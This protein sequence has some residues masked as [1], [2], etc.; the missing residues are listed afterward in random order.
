MPQE[1]SDQTPIE[2]DPTIEAAV[3]GFGLSK[4]LEHARNHVR[5]PDPQATLRQT[6]DSLLGFLA[7]RDPIALLARTGL[8]VIDE[9][10]RTADDLVF[11]QCE[12]EILQSLALTLPQ[13]PQV[14]TSPRSIVRG[15]YLAERTVRAFSNVTGEGID[16]DDP[17][18]SITA[19]ARV[20]TLY[21][22]N[23]F[24]SEDAKA[25]LPT[26]L[27]PMDALSRERLGFC[28]SDFA[29]ALLGLLD[30]IGPRINAFEAPAMFQ[31]GHLDE[32]G[33]S[34]ILSTAPM[35]ERAWRFAGKSPAVTRAQC[36]FQLSEMA[37]APVFTFSQKE[38]QGWYGE[39]I[40][41]ALT[42]LS[43][44]FGDLA[45]YNLER[46]YLDS[47]IREQPFIRLHDDAL[48]L[49]VPGLL[50]SFPFQMIEGLIR[51]D[52]A[53]EAAYSHA[54]A[55][56]L[57][58]AAEAIFRTAMP[59]ARIYHPVRWKDPDSGES[60]ENDL[61]VMLGNHIFL[62]E[63]KSGKVKPASRRGG[64]ESLKKNFRQL[65]VEPGIQAHRLEAILR[66]GPEAQTLLRDS[67]GRPLDIDLSR[68]VIVHS[69]GICIEH[70]AAIT[71][72]REKFVSLGLIGPDDAW[73]PILSLG[74]LRM[75]DA[76]LDT[77]VS[78]FHYLTRRAAIEQQIS[79]HGDEQ[80]LLSMY[81]VNGFQID[82]AALDG[83]QVR[84]G[85][86]DA[87]VRGHKIPR[88]DRGEL[89]TPGVQ[90]PHSWRR[91]AAELY[92]SDNRNRFDMIET[93]MNQ[94][95]Q[96]LADLER[97]ARSYRSGARGGSGEV[98][99]IRYSIGNRT[100]V[101]VQ[102]LS[103]ARFG[104]ESAWHDHARQ[105]AIGLQSTFAATECVVVLRAKKSRAAF[106]AIS[107]FRSEIQ[108][109]LIEKA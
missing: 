6:Q 12:A 59:S 7:A 54:R 36:A 85:M 16:S 73:A 44:R 10:C 79:F 97:R 84:F 105:I 34:A 40:A 30:R 52:T 68:P 37:W 47:P 14:P 21:Y 96:G 104:S 20:Q 43:L 27:K 3:P 72:N 39:T 103:N 63:A 35:A 58:D 50:V 71:S 86:A 89:D 19:E 56:Y 4:L 2:I 51:G 18:A 80:D 94:H 108:N 93:I 48:F 62:L 5:D 55:R 82:T 49:P 77:E 92:A 33:L 24:G 28:L 75:I 31:S 109:R 23:F 32:A 69:F 60:F 107:F 81:L 76:R 13:G 88:Q 98:A 15:W 1:T 11:E 25:I 53:L 45:G 65:Y 17:I 8:H 95:P 78:F 29:A 87:P 9:S 57:E 83:R 66:R 64:L 26:L 100:F 38:L 102:L 106:D 41:H 74:E 42:R 90:L 91:V 61:F 46:L 70:F 67:K 101:V 99:V 22:R